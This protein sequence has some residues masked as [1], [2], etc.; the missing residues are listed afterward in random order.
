MLLLL[1]K[2]SHF[3]SC[4]TFLS[5]PHKH[6]HSSRTIQNSSMHHQSIRALHTQHSDS[7]STA[8][9][10]MSVWM[11]KQCFSGFLSQRQ[12]ELLVAA[13]YMDPTSLSAPTTAASALYRILDL[14]GKHDF[15]IL[16][17][18]VNFA[19]DGVKGSFSRQTAS[20]F[21]AFKASPS[22]QTFSLLVLSSDDFV[23]DDAEFVIGN[24]DSMLERVLL[25]L[26]QN[27]ARSAAKRLIS[28]V[29]IEEQSLGNDM[30]ESS[31]IMREQC[32]IVLTFNSSMHCKG[33]RGHLTGPKYAN[34]KVYANMTKASCSST[35]LVISDSNVSSANTVQEEIV[36]RLRKQFNDVAFFFWDETTGDRLGVMLKPSTF[37]TSAF[38]STNSRRKISISTGSASHSHMLTDVSQIAM[39]IYA[40]GCGCFSDIIFR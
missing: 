34:L 5:D 14:L 16:P 11:S 15:D 40:G 39:N 24:A 35:R 4:L 28:I 30:F 32:N 22:S 36:M 20:A 8:V 17:L 9:R 19:A 12:L 6:S 7:F 23:H 37:I 21:Q 3:P 33:S 27:A 10:L 1:P 29:L 26:V 18:S 2:S 38:S 13:V 31:N 25:L